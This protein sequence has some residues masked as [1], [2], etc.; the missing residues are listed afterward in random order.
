MRTFK[1]RIMVDIREYWDSDGELKPGKKGLY[2]Q[3][4]WCHDALSQAFRYHWNNG[5]NSRGLFQRLTKEYLEFHRKLN[6]HMYTTQIQY[7]LHVEM[8][9]SF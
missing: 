3:S 8:I 2:E 5:K 7:D 9:K 4:K 6:I 1:G